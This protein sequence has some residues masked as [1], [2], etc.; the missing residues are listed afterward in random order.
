MSNNT[1]QTSGSVASVAAA[2]LQD[3]HA[4]DTAK[5][6]AA[7]ALSQTGRGRQTGAA[8]EDLA[9]TVMRSAKYGETTKELA[10][11]VLSQSNKER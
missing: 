4:S 7:S 1:K 9:S 11:S 6:L 2:V 5:S 8:M 3:P 10:A